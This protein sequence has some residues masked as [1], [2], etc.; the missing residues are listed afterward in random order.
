MFLTGSV[1]G[2]DDG[3]ETPVL[4]PTSIFVISSINGWRVMSNDVEILHE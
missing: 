2:I 1:D 3:I 4:S